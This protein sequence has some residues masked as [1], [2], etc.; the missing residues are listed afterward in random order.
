MCMAQCGCIASYTDAKPGTVWY[1]L[2]LKTV[3]ENWDSKAT[4]AG[5]I[6]AYLET[7]ALIIY[8]LGIK[9]FCLP[10]QKA[11]L[12]TNLFFK[13]MLKISAFYLKKQESFI[14]KK[15]D[16]SCSL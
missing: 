12:F 2:Y 11:E 14:P 13:Q 5:T 7:T 9:L 3:A 10:R 4:S 16:L 1:A 6:L 15:Y 8:F